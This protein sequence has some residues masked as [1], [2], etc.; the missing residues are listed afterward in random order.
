MIHTH[1]KCCDCERNRARQNPRQANAIE[2]EGGG[3]TTRITDARRRMRRR[4]RQDMLNCSNRSIMINEYDILY[5]Y[6]YLRMIDE[7]M[8]HAMN[9]DNNMFCLI[10][11]HRLLPSSFP[12]ACRT[13]ILSPRTQ[14]ETGLSKPA[15]C[16]IGGRVDDVQTNSVLFD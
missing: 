14:V 16:A 13:M 5:A 10:F 1:S 4:G 3:I 12:T 11:H 2:G 9:N 7:S 8:L 15:T 6:C